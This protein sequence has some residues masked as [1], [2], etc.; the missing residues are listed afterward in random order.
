MPTQEGRKEE[1]EGK[2]PLKHKS[3]TIVYK[4]KTSKKKMPKQSKIEKKIYKTS[5]ELVLYWPTTPGHE[6]HVE[7]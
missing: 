1:K 4:P 2:N 6:A 3:E 5:T 7:I